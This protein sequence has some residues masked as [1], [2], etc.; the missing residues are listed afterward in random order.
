MNQMVSK[1]GEVSDVVAH[2]VP[3]VLV[4]MDPRRYSRIGW[5]IVLMGVG[6]FLL[7]AMLAPL[8]KGV[9]I[10]GTVNVAGNRQ[11]V[12]YVH[13]G[14]VQ[15]ILVKEG[16]LVKEGQVLVK[17]DAVQ[18]KAAVDMSRGELYSLR[19]AEARLLAERDGKETLTF[20]AELLQAK[21]DLR[22][23]TAMSLQQQLFSSRRGA[24]R[25]E[26]AGIEQNIAGSKAQTIGIKASREAKLTQ[27]AILQEQVTG[28][29][30]LAR[31]GYVARNRLL[32]VERNLAQVVGA[33]A[34][35]AATI[36][37]TQR[38]TAEFTL[39][40]SQ[41]MQEYQRE[42]RTMLSDVQKEASSI[43]SRLVSLDHDLTNVEVR[44]P[45]GGVVVGMAMFSKN[46]VVAPGA[47]MMDIVP[48]V[49]GF[50]IE[51]S[52]PVNLI[53]KVHVGL[54]AKLMFA[55]FNTNT[56][57]EIFGE[58]T[59]VGADRLVDERTGAPYYK[60][61]AKVAKQGLKELA[62]LQIRPGMPVEIF[63]KA[64]ERNMMSY[65]LKPVFDRAK[66][67]MTEE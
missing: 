48:G 2:E 40:H 7:W 61:K 30:D 19:A 13:G 55:A 34:E 22:A 24:L 14:T 28:L 9:P 65:L 49:E 11:A 43:S 8:D 62:K 20:P 64:G 37:R 4:N 25:D 45:V 57:P 35:D 29:R 53:D 39:R 56:T 36:E 41:R 18:S 60:I 5:L 6:G 26:L 10:S 54:P 3:D 33:L 50:D 38:Q 63:I 17:F 15:D 23:S 52:L 27:Q 44:A 58:I 31:D 16:D 67:S 59:Y 32:E 66:T 21:N 12:Q 51:G 47:R 1:K 46:G 42:V